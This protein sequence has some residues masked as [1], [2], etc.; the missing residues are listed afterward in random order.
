VH[1][2]AEVL[3]PLTSFRIHPLD[4]FMFGNILAVTRR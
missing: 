2:S 3:T 4:T 1:H